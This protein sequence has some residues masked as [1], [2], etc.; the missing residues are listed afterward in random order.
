LKGETVH[1]AASCAGQARS[2]LS[3]SAFRAVQVHGLTYGTAGHAGR[4][5]PIHE[6]RHRL[7]H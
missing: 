7:G 6:Q 4:L 1:P 2:R 5:N 3:C